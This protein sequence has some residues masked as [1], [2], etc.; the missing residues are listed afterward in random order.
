MATN[1]NGKLRTLYTI[2]GLLTLVISFT[3]WLGNTH[4]MAEANREELKDHVADYVTMEKRDDRQDR[5]I[6]EIKNDIKYIVKAV[7]KINSK[8]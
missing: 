3:L 4:W 2:T 5:D 8:L 7:D 1:G 6:V